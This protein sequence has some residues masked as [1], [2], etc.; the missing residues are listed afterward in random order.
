MRRLGSVRAKVWVI[1]VTFY[2]EF[3]FVSTRYIS[4]FAR[5]FKARRR[6][7]EGDETE[8]LFPFDVTT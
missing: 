2:M 8:C 6:I 3:L 4:L 5:I 1:S 7:S